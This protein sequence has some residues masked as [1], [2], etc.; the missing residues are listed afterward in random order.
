MS[1]GWGLL[2][3]ELTLLA[4]GFL[5]WGLDLVLPPRLRWLLPYV[6]VLGLAAAALTVIVWARAPGQI[7]DGLIS[8]D[9]YAF[10]F[11]VIFPLLGGLV[12]LASVHFVQKRLAHQGEYYGL[13]TMAVLAMMVM[14]SAGELLTA[15]IAL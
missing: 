6:A 5:V 3:P 8:T 11:R 14:S 15:Y 7:Y 13:I 2:R 4:V 1:T 12:A 10:P 9:G